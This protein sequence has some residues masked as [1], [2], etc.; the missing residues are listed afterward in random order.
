[1]RNKLIRACVAAPLA[2]CALTGAAAQALPAD[3]YVYQPLSE[4]QLRDT[5]PTV[6]GHVGGVSTPEGVVELRSDAYDDLPAPH[7]EP[8]IA[9]TP[10]A[11]PQQVGD[12]QN[13]YAGGEHVDALI[14]EVDGW[15]QQINRIS[16]MLDTIDANQ[17]LNREQ[18]IAAD[19][20]YRQANNIPQDQ[21]SSVV[22]GVVYP[23]ATPGASTQVSAALPQNAS[24]ADKV[25]AAAKTQLGVP[26]VWGGTQANVG[27]DCSGLTQWAYAQVGVNLPRTT[28]DQ[29]NTGTPIYNQA[30][31][32]PGDLV[33][34]HI[35]HVGIAISS[36]EMIHA[37]QPGDVVKIAPIYG[38][39]KGVRLL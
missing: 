33:F 37:P 19:M 12:A 18:Q 4:E 22:D 8:Q 2:L 16:E 14:G 17:Q 35:G 34:P 13:Q 23:P 24:Q 29:I 21:S 9:V 5:P 32:Q 3:P 1:M 20:L 7:L 25:I 15:T 28:Y 30:D 11:G 38:F 36:T 6:G 26:Y 39:Q 10:A 31:I 27:L